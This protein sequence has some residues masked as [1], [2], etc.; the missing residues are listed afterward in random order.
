LR[1]DQAAAP[2][3][4]RAINPRTCRFDTPVFTLPLGCRATIDTTR[5][6]FAIVEPAVR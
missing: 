6:R 1:R 4:G 3:P 5:Q 2:A